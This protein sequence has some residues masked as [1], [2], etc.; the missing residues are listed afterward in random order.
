MQIFS[1]TLR[2]YRIP[3]PNKLFYRFLWIFDA[4]LNML[5]R[6]GGMQKII[7]FVENIQ[8]GDN[9]LKPEFVNDKQISPLLQLRLTVYTNQFTQRIYLT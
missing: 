4:G 1:G 9:L 5:D 6:V 2:R 7:F 8:L 3:L